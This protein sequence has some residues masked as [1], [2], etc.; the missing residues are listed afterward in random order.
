[1][2]AGL[3]S[4]TYNGASLDDSNSGGLEID[5]NGNLYG[6]NGDPIGY[7]SQISTDPLAPA[8]FTLIDFSGASNGGSGFAVEVV[9]EPA[10]LS[11][12]T[13]GTAFLLLGRFRKRN[14]D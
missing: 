4:G 10:S 8:A 6:W 5:P 9:P 12:M 1:V 14:A 3:Q 7:F 11:L 13:A 2:A